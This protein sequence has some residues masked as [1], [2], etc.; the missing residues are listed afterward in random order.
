M[1]EIVEIYRVCEDG[2]IWKTIQKTTT[3]TADGSTER[4]LVLKGTPAVKI[5]Q[6]DWQAIEM[7]SIKFF[8]FLPLSQ[9]CIFFLKYIGTK[10]NKC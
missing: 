7:A 5:F 2:K 1:T 8:F 4:V 6:H 3:I 10:C 9:C